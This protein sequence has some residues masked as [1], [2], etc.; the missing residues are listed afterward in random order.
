MCC[1]LQL[2]PANRA[3]DSE[4]ES[5][6]TAVLDSTEDNNN[7]DLNREKSLAEQNSVCNSRAK[8][9][10]GSTRLRRYC[11]WPS[12]CPPSAQGSQ[13]PRVSPAASNKP[14]AAFG[15]ISRGAEALGTV[16]RG[17]HV[18]LA[19]ICQ[20]SSMFAHRSTHHQPKQLSVASP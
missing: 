19:N 3:L 7:T 8:K 2:A 9:T 16:S 11:G 6:L 4:L 14:N 10:H 18:I 20:V 17:A 5:R 13:C 15:T 1:M 12:L